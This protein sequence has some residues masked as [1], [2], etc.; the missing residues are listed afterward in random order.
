MSFVWWFYTHD[1]EEQER[2][3]FKAR[4]WRPPTKDTPIPKESPWSPENEMAG[5][6]ALKAMAGA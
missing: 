2:D 3:K 1:V 6:H 5:F 4:L